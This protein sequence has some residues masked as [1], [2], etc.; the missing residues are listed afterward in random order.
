[1][2]AVDIDGVMLWGAHARL[3]GKK[4]ADNPYAAAPGTYTLHKAW[5]HGF[6]HAPEVM[7]QWLGDDPSEGGLY[8]DIRERPIR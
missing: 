2:S 5:R 3:W 8:D 6:E 4:L 7:A 1:M